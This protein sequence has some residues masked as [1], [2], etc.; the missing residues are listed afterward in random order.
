M[1]QITINEVRKK[2]QV[3]AK[4][5]KN[6]CDEK[7]HAQQFWRDLYSCFGLSKSSASMF[8]ARVSKINGKRGYIDSFIP[9]LLLVEQKS[10]NRDLQDAY[11]Q[12]LE[13]AMAIK[14]EAEKPRYIIT[15]DFQT[16]HLYDLHKSAKEPF[17]CKLNELHS[18]ADRFMF[19]ADKKL[20][21]IIEETPINRKAAYQISKLHEK[22]LED[23]FVG[24]DLEVFLTRILFCLFAD[25]TGIFGED[26]QFT[27]YIKSTREDG[28]DTGSAIATLFQIL[29]TP[30]DKR[31][32][33]LD[34]R[35]K[36][37]EYVNGNLFAE[38]TE[39]PFFS[40]DLRKILIDCSV[41]DWSDISPA[42]FG[43][44]FQAVL[45]ENAV[46]NK[47]RKNIR[48][49]LGAH[50]T[51]ERNILKVI[52]SLFLDSLWKEYESVKN[53][54]TRLTALYEKL[55]KL[56][57]FDPACGC[58]N[59]LVVAYRELRNL[60]NEIIE[61]LFFKSGSGGLLD[62]STLCRVNIGQFYGIEIDEVATH[63][64]RV[65]LYITDHQSNLV[66]ASKFGSTRATV[67]LVVTPHI[68]CGNALRTDWNDVIEAEKCTY[69][70]GNPP[71][72]GK[73]WQTE[74]QKDDM[75][76]I[77]GQLKNYGLL[78]YVTA[79]YIKATDY[80]NKE[81]NVAFVS[82]NSITQGEQ[83]A[84][85]WQYLFSKQ[86]TINFAHRTFR[87]SNEGKANAGVHCVIIGFSK[88]GALSKYLFIYEGSSSEYKNIKV[89]TISPYLIEAA[90]I[91]VINSRQTIGGGKS[92]AFGSMPNDG[93]NLLLTE[94]ECKELLANEPQ[95][96][97]FIKLF[98][99]GDEFINSIK[100]YCIWLV[101]A[102][103]SQIAAM[104]LIYERVSKVKQIRLSSKRET[105]RKLANTPT[106]F[107]EIRQPRSK[108][109][110]I[111]EVSSERRDYLPIAF[112]DSDIIA[113]NKIY[114]MAN[115]TLYDFAIL[116]SSMHMA[117][118]KTV[119]GRLE[120]RYQYS[121]G[122]VYNNFIWPAN[123][124]DSLTETANSILNARKQF[125]TETLAV[126]YDP[127]TMPLVLSKAHKINDKAVDKA[128]G[129][130][131]A[132]DDVSRVSFLFKL[133]EK[134]LEKLKP[135]SSPP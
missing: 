14:E 117:W 2:L 45:E 120:S 67:P 68:H 49:E 15:C 113:S 20:E 75:K 59:F 10:L 50:Y 114:T 18:H 8:E 116:N 7:Q 132:D 72:I 103:P 71:F 38:R 108:Y 61:Q 112:V 36:S 102:T 79:W 26:N 133:Y 23:N 109:I 88:T 105:T 4:E 77:A 96:K 25:D 104:P 119:C 3:F 81:T 90:Y 95:A 124:D 91:P 80:V 34:E 22:L 128:Y 93:G 84:V 125:E 78:D 56:T 40:A 115:A 32:N 86:I 12:A 52:Q 97:P 106:L 66:A 19:L 89:K 58:G 5:H 64:A 54:K 134:K 21:T 24:K 35:L 53:N 130:K 47:D 1:V 76:L 27:N 6:D 98:I 31:Q 127:I 85:L 126:L 122:I 63:I 92:I 11:D 99:G 46:N 41:L 51:S 74:E 57:F 110:A 44:M 60:E 69:V 83:V 118:M 42:I 39:I 87:W 73:Q 29:N 100:R 13:Y 123:I 30:H 33:S 131:D 43:A 82:T 62:I 17:I 101:D 55:S 37:F 135:I 111:P 94:S 16:F 48:R 9:S 107:G 65:A 70:L 121:A 28:S 129:Y